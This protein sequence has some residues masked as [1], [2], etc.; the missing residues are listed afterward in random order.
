MEEAV[1]GYDS[2]DEYLFSNPSVP[3]LIGGMLKSFED[4]LRCPIV[5]FH[6]KS[7]LPAGV[8]RL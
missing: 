8:G 4:S 7:M 1:T 2:E 3:S 6:P 5:S